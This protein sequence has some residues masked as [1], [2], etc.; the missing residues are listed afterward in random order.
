MWRVAFGDVRSYDVTARTL[1]NAIKK[2]Q[3]RF[4]RDHTFWHM[5]TAAELV[6]KELREPRRSRQKKP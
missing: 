1:I 6:G 5:A 2:A 3:R 4:K